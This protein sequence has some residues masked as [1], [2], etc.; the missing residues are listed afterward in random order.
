LKFPKKIFRKDFCY[1]H[2]D[3]RNWRLLKF[4]KKS[5]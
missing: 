2:L 4:S 3:S 1:P 5:F